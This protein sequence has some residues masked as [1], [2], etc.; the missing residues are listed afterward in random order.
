VYLKIWRDKKRGLF[1]WSGLIRGLAFDRSGLIRGRLLYTV[2]VSDDHN[3]A[4]NLGAYTSNP[5]YDNTTN[6]LQ[7]TFSNGDGCRENTRKKKSIVTFVCKP[8]MY[9]D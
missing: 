4:H 2:F 6:Q 1:D 8:G 3:N 5:V 7:I 9:S